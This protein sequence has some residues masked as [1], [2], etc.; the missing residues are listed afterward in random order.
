MGNIRNNMKSIFKLSKSLLPRISETEM[1][2]LRSGTVSLDRNIMADTVNKFSFK[3][4][5]NNYDNNYLNKEVKM[6]IDS[7]DGPVFENGIV[8]KNLLET[9]KST[10]AFSFII[11]KEHGGLDLN[12]ET[13]SRILVKLAS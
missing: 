9:I 10:K 1:I 5:K 12:V 3:S 6:L 7:C 4:L 13:Q 8:N 2:A 11:G